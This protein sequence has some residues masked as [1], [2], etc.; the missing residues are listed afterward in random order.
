MRTVQY[1]VP[2]D[3]AEYIELISPTTFFGKTAAAAAAAALPGATHT[4]KRALAS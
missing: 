3:L 1:S 2:T 4:E